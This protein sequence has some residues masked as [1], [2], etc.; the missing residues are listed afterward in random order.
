MNK[1]RLTK[2]IQKEL[3]EIAGDEF[4]LFLWNWFRYKTKLY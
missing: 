4:R 1:L 3:I 2:Y